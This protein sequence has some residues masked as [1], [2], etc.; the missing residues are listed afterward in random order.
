M[1]LK[2]NVWFFLYYK[3]SKFPSPKKHYANLYYLINFAAC[4]NNTNNS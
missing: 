1:L 4:Q 2:K 3:I